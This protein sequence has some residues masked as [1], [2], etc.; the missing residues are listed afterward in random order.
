MKK[1]LILAYSDL[2]YD[3]RVRRQIKWLAENYEVTVVC[4]KKGV[5][6]QNV[7]Y[8]EIK[9]IQL[10]KLRKALL[11][12]SLLIRV[13]KLSYWLQHGYYKHLKEL[14]GKGFDLI[15]ANDLETVPLAYRLSD[16]GRIKTMLDAHE[17]SPRHFEERRWFRIFFAPW[18]YALAKKYI[19]RL[20]AMTT[21]SEGLALAYEKEFGT[22]PLLVTN[23]PAYQSLSPSIVEN[24]IKLVHHGIVNKS[25]KLESMIDLMKYLGEGYVLDMYLMIPEYASETTISYYKALK[26]QA[27]KTSNVRVLPHLENDKI[28]SSINAYDIGVFLLEPINFNYANALPNKLFDFIQARLAI[29]IGPTPE[30]KRL[31]VDNDLGVV[32]ERFDAK[33]LADEIK[34]LRPEDISKYKDNSNKA[35]NE[36]SEERNKQLLLDLLKD[37]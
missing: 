4:F 21:V 18:Y 12:I 28:V 13:Y 9:L 3:A 19:P 8:R 27:G 34:K 37:L 16:Q 1:I 29:A 24:P 5:M 17:Y 35:A 7:T 22:K 33:T 6:Y 20:W 15:L 14:S 31:V 10:G 25:R 2:S 23:A 32:S 30:M 11:A 26:D 36:L